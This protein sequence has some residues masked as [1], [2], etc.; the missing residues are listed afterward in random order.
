M[1]RLNRKKWPSCQK[2][3]LF[4]IKLLRTKNLDISGRVWTFP[5]GLIWN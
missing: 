4:D 1:P 3:G 2:W 5:T